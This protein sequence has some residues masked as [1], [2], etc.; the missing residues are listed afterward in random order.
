MLLAVQAFRQ[1]VAVGVLGHALVEG[2]VEHGDVRQRRVERHGRFD[3]EQVG[4][5]VQ[6]RQ[7]RGVADRLDHLGIEPGGMGE[8]FAAMH[9]AVADGVQLALGGAGDQ[10]QQA[11]EGGAVSAAGQRLAVV[12]AVLLPVQDRVWRAQALGQSVQDEVPPAF[13]HQGELDR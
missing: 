7:G 3:A 12:A 11:G 5:V 9:H 13:A 10:R 8:A 6:R 1:G 2:G 4:R